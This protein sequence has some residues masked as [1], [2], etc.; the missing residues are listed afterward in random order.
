M[1]IRVALV[2][3]VFACAPAAPAAADPP[4][5]PLL[6]GVH[7]IV[8]MGD[9]ITEAGGRPGGYVTLIGQYLSA[10]YPATP[11]EIVN[12]GISGHKSTDMQA[13]FDRDVL[14]AKPDLV[15]INVGVNDVWHSFR[16]FQAHKDYP[17][18]SLPNGVPLPL[19]REKLEAMITAAQANGIKVVLLTPTVI[20]ENLE[21]PENQRLSG[22]LD[23]MKALGAA[24]HCPIVDLNGAFTRV[25]ALYRTLAGPDRNLLTVDGVHMNAAGNQLMAWTILRGFGIPEADLAA[26]SIEGDDR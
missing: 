6:T 9:S 20:H 21:S 13:R 15:T 2:L 14:Q 18:G 19:Y 11:I 12:A 10:I 7:R 25:I 4:L 26:A 3:T 23:A 8:T 1:S 16:D 17:D 24:H 5:P 22:Y